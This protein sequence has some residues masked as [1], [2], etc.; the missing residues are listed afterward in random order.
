MYITY[1][2]NLTK[3]R[4]RKNYEKNNKFNNVVD[5]FQFNWLNHECSKR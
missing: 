4:N 3:S 2:Q 5:T 1:T